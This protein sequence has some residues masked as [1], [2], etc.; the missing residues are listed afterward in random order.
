MKLRGQAG[1]IIPLLFL[2]VFVLLALQL[3]PVIANAG[4][5]AEL[6]GTNGTPGVAHNVSPAAAGMLDLLPMLYVVIIVIF[7]VAAMGAG[8]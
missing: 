1:M 5:S 3:A 6:G 2:V 8:M 7:V 4:Q